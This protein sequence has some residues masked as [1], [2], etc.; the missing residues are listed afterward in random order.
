MN[1]ILSFAR[2]AAGAA[3][4]IDTHAAEA[5]VTQLLD[6]RDLDRAQ[7]QAVFTSIVEGNLP[8]ALMA[9]VFVALR[10][11]GETS[12]ELI[13]AAA[14]LR[15]AAQPFPSPDYLFADSCG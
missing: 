11:R 13:G 5:A 3:G 2:E 12:E 6:G 10:V 1:Q 4:A 9:A 7:A 14:A 15:R 8:D